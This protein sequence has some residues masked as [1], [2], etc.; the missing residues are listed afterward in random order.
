MSL[1]KLCRRRS[2][3]S[4]TRTLPENLSAPFGRGA[5]GQGIGEGGC[6]EPAGSFGGCPHPN[7]LPEGE[8]TFVCQNDPS[9]TVKLEKACR[10]CRRNR[11]GA[12]AVEFAI[13][14]PIFFVMIFGMIEFGR[15]I[16]VQ[17]VLTNAS[18]E[19]ARVAVLDSQS[20]TAT[21]VASTVTTYL[22]NAGISGATVTINP[23][24]PTTAGYGAPVTVTVQIPFSKVSWLP[25]P[26][27]L[28]TTTNLTSSTV[29]RRETV[30]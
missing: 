17:Q 12:A 27:F 5:R 13:V 30:Q 9:P 21:Q 23:T 28:G 15:A 18:R 8:G 16:M 1:P 7:P 26:V 3:Y 14:A 10:P 22:Q 20:P 25:T 4:E 11:Q 19:G 6:S 2:L 24:E 29:M